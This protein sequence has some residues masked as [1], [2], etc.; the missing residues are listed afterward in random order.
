MTESEKQNGKKRIKD[1][2]KEK[3]EQNDRKEQRKWDEIKETEEE[4]KR[5]KKEEYRKG[6]EK[7]FM[8]EKTLRK[9]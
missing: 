5:L 4:R 2:Q 1:I 8:Y 9:R 6:G 7:I 3:K